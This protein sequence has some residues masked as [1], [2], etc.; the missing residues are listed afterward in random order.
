MPYSLK[1]YGILFISFWLAVLGRVMAQ[2]S[3]IS[4][5]Q[6]V[7]TFDKA[8]I[9]K[10]KD[11]PRF[12]YKEVQKPASPST[13]YR[14]KEW[15]WRN[16]W[17]PLSDPDKHPVASKV[18]YLLIALILLYAILKLINADLTGI[19]RREPSNK[20]SF[21]EVDENIHEMNFAQLIE[22]AKTKQNYRRA[23]RLLYLQ[24]LKKLSDKGFIHWEID[25]TN[26]EYVQT[27]QD[28]ALKSDFQELTVRFEYIC[29]GDFHIDRDLFTQTAPLFERFNAR[30]TQTRSKPTHT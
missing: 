11:D 29:Y 12:Q 10:Y 5:P 20:I 28:G 4:V 6:K 18:Y 21:T 7:P 16:F 26:Q 9:Q 17:E 1:I 3:A 8:K 30:I 15:L 19:F 13:I 24:S 23:I 27:L 25:K 14:L 22:E 2:D